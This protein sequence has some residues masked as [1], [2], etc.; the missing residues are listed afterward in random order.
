MDKTEIIDRVQKI[1]NAPSTDADLKAIADKWLSNVGTPNERELSRQLLSE[2]QLSVRSLD[3]TLE[4]FN[5]P[6]AADIFGDGLAAFKKL[7]AEAKAKGEK[8]CFCEACR[9]GQALLD[10][11][12]D[13]LS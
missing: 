5:T 6:E 9:N 3:D 13:I 11:R 8:I 12:E 1:A 7:G 10:A 2:L 4:F